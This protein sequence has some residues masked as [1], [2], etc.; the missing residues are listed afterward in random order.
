MAKSE[1]TD[2]C[3]SEY[4][5]WQQHAFTLIGKSDSQDADEIYSD[6]IEAVLGIR[7][8]D[9]CIVSFCSS[10]GRLE[11]LIDFLF[12]IIRLMPTSVDAFNHLGI[13]LMRQG[14][15]SAAIGC[16][17]Q[18]LEIRPC[19][20]GL[21]HNLGSAFKEIGDLRS[22]ITAYNTALALRPNWIVAI[23]SLSKIS[24]G[25]DRE[26]L[27]DMIRALAVKEPGLLFDLEVIEIIST[28]GSEF[29][30]EMLSC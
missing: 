6:L 12:E 14:D 5:N 26:Q 21:H 10:S 8:G 1:I 28:L 17:N 25:A 15:L 29:A 16:F 30:S 27:M 19:H 2:G 24:T 13:A 3:V 23:E 4:V 22:A 7:I 9:G 20:P 11:E 18:A